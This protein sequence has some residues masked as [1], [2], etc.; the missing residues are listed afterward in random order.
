MKTRF[1]RRDLAEYA[2]YGFGAGIPSAGVVR[3]HA[4]R[5]IRRDAVVISDGKSTLLR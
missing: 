5:S 2:T 3:R 4:P 1:A